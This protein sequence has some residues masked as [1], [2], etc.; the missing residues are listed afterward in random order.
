MIRTLLK[1]WD[2]IAN[3]IKNLTKFI[4]I[5]EYISTDNMY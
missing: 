2:Q 4:E 5:H 3:N 1:Q